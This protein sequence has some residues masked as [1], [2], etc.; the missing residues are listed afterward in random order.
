MELR[1]AWPWL[2]LAVAASTAACS[3]DAGDP[4]SPAGQG[5]AAGAGG[6]AGPGGPGGQGGSSP[7]HPAPFD[8]VGIVGTGQSLS[9][10]AAG[11]P[12]VSV[13]QPYA[14]LKLVDASPDPK[15]DGAGDALSLEPLTAPIRPNSDAY[16]PI[17]YPNNI[18][19][20]TPNEGMGNQLYALT[21]AV[22]GF[23]TVTVHTNVGE[24]GQSIHVIE[25]GGSG[26]AYASTLYE[27]AAIKALADQAGKTFGYGAVL[28]TH[29]ETD[30]LDQDYGTAL[31]KLWGD[32]NADLKAITG[33]TTS[34]PVIL[35]QQST[36]P[37]DVGSASF[38]TQIAWRLG[39]DYPGDF[40]CAGPKYQYDYASDL[41]HLTAP[42]YRRLGAKY[43]EVYAR[44]LL[45]DEGWR[46][47]Q[48]ATA[49]IAG[50]TI[51]VRFDVPDPP[52]AWE[53]TIPP[54]HQ[55]VLPE[56]AAG[57]GF[58]VLD[59][60]GALTITGVAIEGDTIV[61]QLAAPPT[62][63]D[64]AVGYAMAQDGQG[65][66]GGAPGGRRGQ[67]RDSDAFVGYEVRA[68][69]CAVTE[70]SSVVTSATPGLFAELS[71][72]D[73]ATGPGLQGDAVV[74]ARS[75]DSLTL[76]Q[77]WTGATGEASITFRND[78]RNYAV[79][80]YLPVPWPQP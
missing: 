7:I 38:S 27:A 70:G 32:Y 65:P 18:Y 62:G 4:P 2:F 30:A 43:A 44:A 50:A 53:E 13:T 67:L 11:L 60:T 63:A 77:P 14:N 51:T 55:Q 26:K 19:G 57:R 9:V 39:V 6:G 72:T 23:D 20:E 41:V 80:F 68:I 47:L 40:Y 28:L 3:G 48:P 54:P 42:Q 78:Q 31:R 16:P 56:W 29:G 76:S 71:R 17:A 35:T 45:S 33:Q 15:Y 25:K 59:S 37:F 34:I 5:G 61:L 22:G 69:P 10:G 73:L 79:Q 1:A 75:G 49:S 46:P 64:L 58:E 52:L 21:R 8:W 12:V 36:F 66:G 24:S 74:V